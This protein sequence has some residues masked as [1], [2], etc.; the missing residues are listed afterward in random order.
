MSETVQSSVVVR[1]S[2]AAL[3]AQVE[4]ADIGAGLSA[5]Q[6]T[7]IKAALSDHLV[8]VLRGQK[9]TDEQ[10]IAFSEELGELDP[11]GPNPYSGGPIYPEFPKLNVISNII[12]GDKPIGNLGA[13]EA[14]WHADMTYNELPPKGAILYAVELPPDGGDT[15]FASLRSAYDT[16][17][18]A[19]KAKAQGRKAVH[20]ASTN[21][22][23]I[24]RRGYE[25]ITDVRQT[26]G[27]HHP[28][29]RTD[30]VSGR[31]S[32]FLGRRPRSYVPPLEVAESDAL[33]D[34]LW[35][36]ATQE[37]FVFT[38]SWQL[39]D[40]LIWDNLSVLHRRDEFDPQ[41]RRRLHRA[42]LKGEHAIV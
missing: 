22:A 7:A 14:V 38:H 3:G 20:D 32:L 13:G 24:R 33:L 28:L 40:L 2:G 31:R 29:V 15:Q 18:E 19:L 8:I 11:P 10:L 35:A 37:Q 21:S 34:E 16:L 39:G 42:Q 27:A 1:P 9:I 4:G 17:P 26:P 6:V 12:E 36:H 30:P 23:G 25:E 5:E 41:S